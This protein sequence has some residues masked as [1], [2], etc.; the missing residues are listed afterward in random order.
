MLA[1]NLQ[2]INKELTASYKKR[3]EERQKL[4]LKNSALNPEER[5]SA[6][7]VKLEKEERDILKKIGSTI[8]VFKD[9]KGFLKELLP[10]ISPSENEGIYT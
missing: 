9:F 2:E 8:K 10:K 7:K 6:R 3:E 5:K 4:T 1:Q